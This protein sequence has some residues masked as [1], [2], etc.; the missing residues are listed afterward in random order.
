[1]IEKSGDYRI[2]RWCHF[3]IKDDVAAL[4]HSISLNVIFLRGESGKILP[5]LKGKIIKGQK[6]ILEIGED[7][8]NLLLREKFIVLSSHNEME[9]LFN[10]RNRLMNEISLEMMYLLLTDLCNLRCKYCFE[11]APSVPSSFKGTM[12]STK[13][14]RYALE[15]FARLT[16]KYGNPDKKKIIHLYGGEPLLNLKVVREVILGIEL[17]KKEKVLPRECDIVIITNGTLVTE[18]LA[19]FF[20]EYSV[21]VGISVDGP[22]HINNIYRVGKDDKIDVFQKAIS[23]YILLRNYGVNTGLSVTLTPEVVQNFDEV[24][25]YFVNDLMVR[26]GVNFNILHFNPAVPVDFQYFKSAA[27]CLIKAFKKFRELGIYEERMM[28][29]AQSFAKKELMF[30]DCGVVGH[31]IVVAPDGQIGVCQDFVKPRTYFKGS[32]Y[33]SNFDPVNVGLFTEWRER[34]PLF[35]EDCFDCQALGVCGGG[36][37]ASIELKTGNRWN[38]DERICPHSKLSLEW[39]IWDMYLQLNLKRNK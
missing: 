35:M 6:I 28:R 27:Q 10:V 21:N 4:F 23:S 22:K 18:N 26:D 19:K 29:K 36:C 32:V 11:D 1:M 9:Y 25:D 24:L 17:L 14:A 12:M 33:D 39:L 15:A 2:S 38:I 31:Q 30:A 3:F 5:N 13:T 20:A 16:G 34:S 8:A 37:P 7:A